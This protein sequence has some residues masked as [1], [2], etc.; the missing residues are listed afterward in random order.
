MKHAVNIMNKK[1]HYARSHA[2]Y[3]PQAHR[4]DTGFGLG[5]GLENTH[6]KHLVV[7]LMETLSMFGPS[8]FVSQVWDV[9]NT[10]GIQLF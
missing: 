1:F 6:K 10:A 3:R 8:D 5:T 4:P 7:Y 9:E 2:Y